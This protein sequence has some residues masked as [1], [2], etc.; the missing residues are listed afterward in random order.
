MEKEKILP[1]THLSLPSVAKLHF[2]CF[3]EAYFYLFLPLNKQNNR[4]WS[5]SEP[6]LGVEIALKDE[7]VF[8]FEFF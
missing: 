5:D 3:E 4:I 7:K 8:K 1:N 6:F 2:I